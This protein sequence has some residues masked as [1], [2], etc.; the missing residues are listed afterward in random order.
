MTSNPLVHRSGDLSGDKV[1]PMLPLGIAK[2][3]QRL[4]Q[5]LR[6]S[7]KNVKFIHQIATHG[8]MGRLMVSR[9]RVLHFS[10]HGVEGQL[11][12]ESDQSIG[13]TQLITKEQLQGLCLS[14]D[15]NFVFMMYPI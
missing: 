12:F 14:G 8:N 9:C 3:K 2:E 7:G 5:T 1:S 13:E 6:E 15:V 4:I 11:A 10:G